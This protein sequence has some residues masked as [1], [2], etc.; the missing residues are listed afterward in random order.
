MCPHPLT[1]GAPFNTHLLVLVLQPVPA[2]ATLL[3]V[4]AYCTAGGYLDGSEKNGEPL[5]QRTTDTAHQYHSAA[6]TAHRGHS[7]P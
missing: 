1:G 7:E 6:N 4:A 2:W 3:L 5:T